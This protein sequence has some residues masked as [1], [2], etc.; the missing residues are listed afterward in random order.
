M[1]TARDPERDRELLACS[2]AIS[3]TLISPGIASCYGEARTFDGHSVSPLIGNSSHQCWNATLRHPG[4][5]LADQDPLGPPLLS[6]DSATYS[7]FGYVTFSGGS[8]QSYGL[9]MATEAAPPTC[10]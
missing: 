2:Q 3:S 4:E 6:Q 8:A 10:G 1:R 5:V 9:V 7:R